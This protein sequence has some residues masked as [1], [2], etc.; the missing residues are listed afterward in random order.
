[1]NGILIGVIGHVDHGKSA[2]VR[3]L[4]GTETD[5]LPEEKARGLSILPGFARLD[6]PAGTVEFVD[7]P[8]HER[9]V[10]AMISG[11]T[12]MGAVLLVVAANE[13]V[14]PQTLEH[15]EIARLLGVRRGLAVLAKAD[16]A[17][18]ADLAAR[19]RDVSALCA[20]YGFAEIP[21]LAVSARTGAGLGRLAAAL[22]SFIPDG[23]AARDD[24][25]AYLPV[26]RVFTV[27]GFGPV[28]TGTLR[29]GTL[30]VGDSVELAPGRVAQ[31]RSLQ[32]HGRAVAEA[33]PGQRAAV[34]L[35]GIE[36]GALRR[37][38]ALASPGI[39]APSDWLDV[40]LDVSRHASDSIRNGRRLRLLFGTSEVPVRVRLIAGDEARPG[41]SVPAQLRCLK[42]VAIPARE[43]FVLR[44]DTP[45]RTVGG[46]LVLDPSARRRRRDGANAATVQA[47]AEGRPSRML[48]ARLR[49]AGARGCAVADLARLVGISPDRVRRRLVEIGARPMDG[50]VVVG[51][52]VWADLAERVTDGLAGYHEANPFEAG[53]PLD[54]VTALAGAAAPGIASALLSELTESGRVVRDGGA[55]RLA[56]HDPERPLS[57]LMRRIE[58]AFRTAGLTPP[59]EAAILSGGEERAQALHGLVRRGLLVRTRDRVQNRTIVFHR[60]AID[61]A[62][63]VLAETFG[64]DRPFLAREAGAALG[65]SRKFSIPLLEHLDARRVTIRRG[66]AR[67]LA[68]DLDPRA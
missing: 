12:G 54:R 7:C 10:R 27:P 20:R 52:E 29:R 45:A 23:P 33:R 38:M 56:S 37:G 39:L 49:E 32:H 53:E 34:A 28:A 31:V 48:E 2:L 30:R 18:E 14:K 22:A 51:A 21:V 44:E 41:E 35:R 47:M 40:M 60:Q 4:T 36:Q 68:P 59:D 50:P 24:G 19:R 61:A 9:F 5:R 1:M 62:L 55:V 67:I 63:A 3:A 26:D 16:L 43:P 11:A 66:D 42:P 15:L 6:T 65:I 46:G 57:P 58:A 8:G 64:P 25:F 13:G 17:D